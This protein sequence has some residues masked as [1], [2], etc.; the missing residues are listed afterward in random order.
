MSYPFFDV[1]FTGVSELGMRDRDGEFSTVHSTVCSAQ[2]SAVRTCVRTR[3]RVCR[4]ARM[5]SRGRGGLAGRTRERETH[6]AAESSQGQ[7]WM[8]H[9]GCRCSKWQACTNR[10]N[11]DA[12]RGEIRA[13]GSLVQCSSGISAIGDGNTTV[14]EVWWKSDEHL[15]RGSCLYLPQHLPHLVCLNGDVQST[16]CE[17]GIFICSHFCMPS[18]WC[19]L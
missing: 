1:K 5:T 10:I 18:H 14:E 16:W 11:T 8:L 13:R 12:H 15:L 2:D 4:V 19:K 3:D 7:P 9:A 6:D 17:V